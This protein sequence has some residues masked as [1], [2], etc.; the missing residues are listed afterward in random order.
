MM[1][2]AISSFY[3]LNHGMDL[4]T[5]G[6]L[7]SLQSLLFFFLDVPTSFL[8]DKYSRK[9][10]VVLAI[11]LGSIWLLLT[12]LTNHVWLFFLAEILNALSLILLGGVS[13]AYIFDNAQ[14]RSFSEAIFHKMNRLQFFFMA[15]SSF[16][17]GV[18][19]GLSS[20]LPWL[21]AGCCC[22]FLT[23]LGVYILPE[24]VV[25]SRKKKIGVKET[26]ASVKNS[27]K[28]LFAEGFN[29]AVLLSLFQILLQ[30]WQPILQSVFPEYVSGLSFGII[31]SLI[32]GVQSLAG[33]LSTKWEKNSLLVDSL[34]LLAVVLPLLMSFFIH[35]KEKVIFIILFILFFGV[36]QSVIATA[37][38][39][40]H[41]LIVGEGR[42]VYESLVITLSKLI[43][44]LALPLV[45]FVAYRIGWSVIMQL[46]TVFC[47][48]NVYLCRLSA[49]LFR[50]AAQ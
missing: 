48:F 9:W 27:S 7:K 4:V 43:A 10:A 33:H 18:F 44:L 46:F 39:R 12:G 28:A 30:Y 38:T 1:V 41:C 15:I 47:L 42:S 34:A 24:G 29:L 37:R 22:F 5:L 3:L 50:G 2:G 13:Y 31:F 23:L 21:I 16:I 20:A 49:F 45:A 19:Y 8:A 40:Y 17:G 32:L 35:T 14:D 6:F 36:I 25:H 26:Y 11:F